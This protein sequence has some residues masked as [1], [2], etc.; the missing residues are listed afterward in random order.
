M[1][2]TTTHSNRDEKLKPKDI[3]NGDIFLLGEHILFCWDSRDLSSLESLLKGKEIQLLLTDPPYGIDY[4]ASKEAFN[5]STKEHEDI[6]NDGFQSD[7]EY[8]KFTQAWLEPILPYLSPK[9]ACYIFNSDKMIFA[10]REG[11]KRAW[12]KFSQL[13]IWV[14]DSAI[15]WRL[16]YLPQHELIAYGWHGTHR[17]YGSK[18]KSILPFAKVRKNTIHPTMKPIPLLRELILNSTKRGEVIYDP[19]GWSGSTLIASEQT[20]RICVMVEQSPVYIERIIKRWETLTGKQAVKID[21]SH[22]TSH[23]IS[24][25]N[26]IYDH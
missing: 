14:K 5:E 6:A 4:V 20:G 26:Q 3:I 2:N 12:W 16:D 13:L 22:P 10:L 7:E 15:I 18:S 11:M 19:F 17:F 1:T 8:A 9:N 21:T 25:L 24:S 23:H